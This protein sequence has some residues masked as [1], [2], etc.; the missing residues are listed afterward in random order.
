MYE[1]ALPA[2]A[3][4]T[5]YHSPGGLLQDQLIQRQVRH[6]ATKPGV[7]SLELLQPLHLTAL[8]PA[9]LPA[10]TVIRHLGHAN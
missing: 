1:L 9:K 10:L 4:P 5:H 3:S 2:F 7:L 6:G 8:Q